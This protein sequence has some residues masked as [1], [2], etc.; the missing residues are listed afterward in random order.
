M[1]T[2]LTLRLDDQLIRDA[3]HY[4]RQSGKSLSQM[5]AEYFS[6]VTSP[7]TVRGELTPAVSRLR[8]AL[9]GMN[10]DRED[11]RRY[12]EGKHL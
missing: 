3:K 4:A 2:K 10:V 6:A 1:Q 7:D 12:L 5:V 9:A 8:G 11:Y